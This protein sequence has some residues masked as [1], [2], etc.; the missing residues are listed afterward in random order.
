[1]VVG[2]P[3]EDEEPVENSE[4]GADADEDGVRLG[5]SGETS[6]CEHGGSLEESTGDEDWSIQ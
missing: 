4:H 2:S 5:S 3:S 6:H 1:M